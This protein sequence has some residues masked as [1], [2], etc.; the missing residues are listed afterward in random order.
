[1]TRPICLILLL[2]LATVVPLAA[3]TPPKDVNALIGVQRSMK[4]A[5]Q[6]IDAGRTADAVAVLESELVNADGNAQ[7]LELLRSA[8]SAHLRQ[9]QSQKADAA[10]IESFRRRLKALDGKGQ[11][12]VA[13]APE[14]SASVL[15]PAPPIPD[16]PANLVAPPAPL[17]PSPG[18]SAAQLVVPPK[19]LATSDPRDPFQQP[20]RDTPPVGSHLPQASAAFAARRYAEAATLFSEAAAHQESFS[21]AQRDEWAYSRLHGVA[22]RLNR[23]IPSAGD[24]SDLA[25]EV[26]DATKG[27]S[28]HIASF[29][30]QL[31]TE[32]RRRN[33]RTGSQPFDAGW[34]VGDTANF[35]VFHRGQPALAAEAGQ[36][37]EAARKDM[38]ERWAGA[39]AGPWSS[40]R[41][42]IYLHAT[43]TEYAQATGKSVESPGHSTI[44]TKA[45]RVVARRIDLRLDEPAIM[46]GVL[47]SE[48]TQVVLADMFADQPLPRWAIVGMAALSESPERVGRYSRAVPPML[49]DKK[50]FAVGPFLDQ[51]NFP[52]P[53]TVTAF[54][55]E[56]VSLVLYLVELKGPK[57]FATF[58]RE[59][60]RRGY[61]RALTAHYGF[62]DAA[63]FQDHWVRHV[64]GGE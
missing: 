8:Y 2:S 23:G 4:V 19:E 18:D 3:E 6:H 7:F 9:L 45:G 64:L 12:V 55:A 36:T 22:M 5:R 48:V 11:P 30:S 20:I 61:A 33:S 1:M 21:P 24:L 63:D 47:P 56:S 31:S 50:L 17:G 38:Y 27:G 46:D 42:D 13:P 51:P 58:L 52:D 49:R 53:N 57:A 14:V 35:R 43:A 16:A 32:I 62:K 29:A 10:T 44:Q 39:P 60:P 28:E 37:A 40:P 41:C 54:Y 34:Q 15:S 26:D 59:A 25:L